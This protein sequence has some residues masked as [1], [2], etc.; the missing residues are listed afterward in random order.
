MMKISRL[1][2]NVLPTFPLQHEGKR[3]GPIQITGVR[4]PPVPW[5]IST[6]ASQFL[7]GIYLSLTLHCLAILSVS[8]PVHQKIL[9]VLCTKRWILKAFLL[10]YTI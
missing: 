8:N 6:Q 7:P 10:V 4:G 2:L 3:R 5:H 1:H 9:E